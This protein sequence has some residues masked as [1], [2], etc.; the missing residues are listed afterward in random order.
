MFKR[1]IAGF[2]LLTSSFAY[3]S[4][5]E[6]AK[7]Y[8]QEKK[9]EKAF[10]C[11]QN[12]SSIE[13]QI[14]LGNAYQFGCGCT[15]D[16]AKAI[17]C[18]EK[19]AIEGNARAQYFLGG[20]YAAKGHFKKAHF[21]LEKSN[22]QGEIPAKHLL[23]LMYCDENYVKHD[24]KKAF[25]FFE[26]AALA[27]H[28]ESQ[29]AISWMYLEGKGIQQDYTKA[30][31]WAEKALSQGNVDAQNILSKLQELEGKK[32]AGKAIKK[33]PTLDYQI[34]K[35]QKGQTCIYLKPK[36]C[37][38]NINM[39]LIIKRAGKEIAKKAVMINERD[40]LIDLKT[41]KDYFLTLNQIAEGEAIT[42][43]LINTDRNFLFSINLIPYPIEAKD[44]QGHILVVKRITP[45]MFF[46]EAKGFK[47]NEVVEF[48]S[49]S[50]KEV[51][52]QKVAVSEEGIFAAG[53]SP[54]TIGHYSGKATVEVKGTDMEKLSVSFNWGK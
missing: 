13:A 11:L 45:E 43:E 3:T 38:Q 7:Q 49:I 12:D 21:W 48:S 16:E 37:P 6:I 32:E 8:M 9:F 52:K 39:K 1:I 20:L 51:I 18:Y 54:A 2:C 10:D 33:E 42:L 31:L 19:A 5:V 22:M 14:L 44:D 35:N 46:V 4:Q 50:G 40:S 29:S 47:P 26:K 34:E 36:N 28:A 24:Y 15:Q 27:N 25:A 53:I 30:A 17:Q 23:G 41:K